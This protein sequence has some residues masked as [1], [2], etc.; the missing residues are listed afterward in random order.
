MEYDLL[1]VEPLSQQQDADL[2][3]CRR[4][5]HQ[6]CNSKRLAVSVVAIMTLVTCAMQGTLQQAAI[7]GPALG[8]VASAD[9]V[10]AWSISIP[11]IGVGLPTGS[12]CVQQGMAVYAAKCVERYPQATGFTC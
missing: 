3:G 10:K 9:E 2:G 11:P 8:R 5:N 4:W 12:G 7:P 1:A 6:Q